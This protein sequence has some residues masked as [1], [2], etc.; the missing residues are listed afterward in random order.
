MFSGWLGRWCVCRCARC[1]CSTDFDVVFTSLIPFA[2]R[3][4]IKSVAHSV[5][6]SPSS[7]LFHPTL[8]SRL[9][10][11]LALSLSHYSRSNTR[12]HAFLVLYPDLKAQTP[13][14]TRTNDCLTTSSFVPFAMAPNGSSFAPL[15]S[16]REHSF[17]S[18]DVSPNSSV[19]SFDEAMKHIGSGYALHGGAP[20][21]P[22]RHQ[23]D[24]GM[25]GIHGM[26]YQCRAVVP[27]GLEPSPVVEPGRAK[28]GHDWAHHRQMPA[29]YG[30]VY[31]GTDDFA[32]QHAVVGTVS[33][34]RAASRVSDEPYAY[35][36]DRGNGEY[37]RLIPADMLP[38]LENVPR[39][40]RGAEGMAVLPIPSGRAP[41]P[42]TFYFKVSRRQL[43]CS[44]QAPV[45]TKLGLLP[46]G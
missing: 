2:R 42:C 1:A 8:Y 7:F 9:G 23:Q 32:H 37:T 26:D 12:S 15:T 22:Y 43:P 27:R 20:R 11:P 18:M 10:S 39:R 29:G 13:I 34:S 25:Q 6:L 21:G 5:P 16:R 28:R 46:V 40:Q 31:E 30:N 41:P 45:S 33:E 14:A 3:V 4:Y 17:T 24:T 19:G 36:F 44:C 35:C 38:E